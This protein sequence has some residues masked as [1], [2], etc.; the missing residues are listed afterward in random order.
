MSQASGRSIWES[1]GGTAYRACRP[2]PKRPGDGGSDC[3]RRHPQSSAESIMSCGLPICVVYAVL[4]FLA[5]S[6]TRS[7][8]VPT[9]GTICCGA[10]L[11]PLNAE[12]QIR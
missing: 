6:L 5:T 1:I 7:V 10:Q 11:V 9:P 8:L 3:R 4:P 12:Y 2:I